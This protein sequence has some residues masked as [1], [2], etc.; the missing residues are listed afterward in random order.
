MSKQQTQELTDLASAARQPDVD[1]IRNLV[2]RERAAFTNRQSV[3][4]V[5]TVAT[6]TAPTAGIVATALVTAKV[7]GLFLVMASGTVTVGAVEAA[8]VTTILESVTPATAGVGITV[9]GGTV[10]SGSSIYLSTGTT[11]ITL[12]AATG[13]LGSVATNVE[14]TGLNGLASSALVVPFSFAGIYGVSTAAPIGALAL[15]SIAAFSLALT[16]ATTTATLSN[17]SF[18]TMEL[19]A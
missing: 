2:Q 3:A 12:A 19:P 13:S 18:S 4:G 5:A 11:A 6:L 17:F 9:T 10:Q 1:Y 14:E 7:S 8:G 16:V 15:G